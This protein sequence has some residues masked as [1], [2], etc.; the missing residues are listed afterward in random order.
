MVKFIPLIGFFAIILGRLFLPQPPNFF[1]MSVIEAIGLVILLLGAALKVYHSQNLPKIGSILTA[2]VLISITLVSWWVGYPDGK[3]IAQAQAY[4]QGVDRVLTQIIE[5]R[6]PVRNLR[7]FVSEA[8]SELEQ[9]LN[10][11]ADLVRTGQV[12]TAEELIAEVNPK[13][14]VFEGRWNC[15]TEG[16]TFGTSTHIWT[17][18]PVQYYVAWIIG[19][20]SLFLALL[21]L[22]LVSIRR[23]DWRFKNNK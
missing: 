23:E 1:Y 22:N 21:E 3:T 2:V 14:E 20:V 6:R 5:T 8:D 13:I 18:N 15:V 12:N 19:A 9:K 10:N 17:L 16:C 4:N 11:A 7:T